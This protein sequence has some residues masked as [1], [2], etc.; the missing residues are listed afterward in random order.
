MKLG[1]ILDFS[2]I[3]RFFSH[4]G[5]D[6]SFN[7]EVNVEV[8][9]FELNIRVLGGLL[10]AFALTNDVIFKLKAEAV[11]KILLKA[12]RWPSG[13]PSSMINLK[14]GEEKRVKAL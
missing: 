8:S 12:F 13:L 3:F 1:A 9:V 5:D 11:G 4:N 2:V 10:S 14:T 6:Q 7:P